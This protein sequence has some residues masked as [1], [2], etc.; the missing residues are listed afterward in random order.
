MQKYNQ[1]EPTAD[2][3]PWIE[4]NAILKFKSL[5]KVI[6]NYFSYLDLDSNYVKTRSDRFMRAY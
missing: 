5:K 4:N 6:V 1:T 2:G 3:G